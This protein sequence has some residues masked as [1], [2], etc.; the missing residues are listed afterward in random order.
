MPLPIAVIDSAAISPADLPVMRLQQS[1]QDAVTVELK[2]DA[3]VAYSIPADHT[4]SFVAVETRAA[5][6]TYLAKNC[7][8]TD[9]AS[10]TIEMSFAVAELP[11]VGL[12][13]GEF[14]VKTSAAV[15][16]KRFS[17]YVEI[18]PTLTSV[19]TNGPLTIAEI[20]MAMRDRCGDDN[21]MLDAV[22]FSDAEII[23]CIRRPIDWWNESVPTG[24]DTYSPTT[25]PYRYHWLN[26]VIGELLRISGYNLM[27][28]RLPLSGGGIQADD[29]ARGADYIQLGDKLVKEWQG[30]ARAKVRQIN[31]AQWIGGTKIADFGRV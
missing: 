14:T 18:T 21:F 27:R 6:S 29:K 28:N 26:G 25:F 13:L 23:A 11:L 5:S 9:A 22:E 8:I 19:Q 1:T 20:R 30:W 24:F 31:A 2:S 3:G 7:T 4:V 10:G 17:C 16:V 12:W 15:P